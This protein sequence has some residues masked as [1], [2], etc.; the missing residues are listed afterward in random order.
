MPT[1][2]HQT[3]CNKLIIVLA[4]APNMNTLLPMTLIQHNQAQFHL[5][6]LMKRNELH[7]LKECIKDLNPLDPDVIAAIE[8]RVADIISQGEGARMASLV[9]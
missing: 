9:D 1:D 5:I 6:E 4:I 7:L 2:Q 3:K 8:D